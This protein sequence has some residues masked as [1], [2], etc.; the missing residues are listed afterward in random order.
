MATV[1]VWPKLKVRSLLPA[2][3]QHPQALIKRRRGVRFS[4]LCFVE[5]R[6]LTVA[7]FQLHR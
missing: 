4:D 7:E 3:V 5:K 6:S 1:L 2:S